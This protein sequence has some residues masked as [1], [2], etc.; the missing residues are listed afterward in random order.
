MMR[1]VVGCFALLFR[2]CACG[3]AAT[4]AC[5]SSVSSTFLVASEFAPG[6]GR[7]T[8]LV[9]DAFGNMYVAGVITS[10]DFGGVDSAVYTNAGRNHRF[11][12]KYL[13]NVTAPAYTAVVGLPTPTPEGG[14]FDAFGADE[15][16]GLAIDTVGNA[17][18]VAYEGDLNYP[19]TG[20]RRVEPTGRKYVYR[21]S[22]AGVASRHSIALDAAVRR[23]GAIAIDGTGAIVL[24]GSAREGLVTTAN[25]PF[26]AAGVAAGCLA[27][28]VMKL[29]P[30]GQTV[31]YATYLGVSGTAGQACG[32][33]G[34]GQISP[35]S[36]DPTGFAMA[37]DPAGNLYVTGQ[38]TPGLAATSGALDL[39]TKAIGPYPF[40]N[41]VTDPA[42]HAFVSKIDPAGHLVFVA[43]VG[44]S[45][46][47]RA[48]SIVVDG[49][50]SPVIAGKTSSR[51]FPRTAATALG[52]FPFVTRDCLLWTPEV[53]FM[54]RLSADFSRLVFSGFLAFD[55]SE[56]DDCSGFSGLH[57]AKLASDAGG[58]LY[59][60]GF[61]TPGNRHFE[62]SAA[63]IIPDQSPFGGQLLQIYSA[64]G[65]RLLYS[66]ALGQYGV[67]GIAV[68]QWQQVVLASG[69]ALQRLVP[70]FLPVA[71]EL[72]ATA[73]CAGKP[74]TLRA[75]IAGMANAQGTVD[76][77][78][79]DV[80]VGSAHAEGGTAVAMI[81]L[82]SVGIR[83][84][85][86]TYR[87]GGPFDGYPSLEHNFPL[88]QA[89]TCP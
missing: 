21:V 50:G 29:D 13:P 22:A 5:A 84:L 23:I 10:Y 1:A 48:T 61:T 41:L 80:I 85:K 62:A 47:D 31:I 86:A 44:G 88:N 7:L 52:A 69:N 75:S 36:L 28:F 35:H 79:D 25:A 37:L 4:A 54:A 56:L 81:T 58:N 64:D 12:A 3:L 39:G 9:R 33:S 83:K 24:T 11:V 6:G 27:P 18:L 45:L 67:H 43:R 71:L 77:A 76:F 55:G 72:P 70:G 26:S 34:K 65:T 40:N 74:F 68:D 53:G 78:S 59:V 14:L 19:I 30:T 63:P 66:S 32:G 2:F 17:F 57:P 46:R 16:I 73:S 82:S 20:G 8:D 49:T 51:D 87:G 42:S 89:G 38:A 60:A 15:A